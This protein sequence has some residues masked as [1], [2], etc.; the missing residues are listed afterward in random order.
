MSKKTKSS[1]K[2]KYVTVHN[3][4]KHVPVLL[5]EVLQYL[6]PQKGDTYLDVTAGYGGHAEAVLE[7]SQ[8]GATLIDRDGEAVKELQASFKAPDIEIVHSDFLSASKQL[9][10]D[11]RR[12]DM[13]VA[14][15][16]VSSPHLNISSRGFSFHGNAPL[17]MRMD[18]N[19]DLSAAEVVNSYPQERLM[20]I[21][22]NLGEEPKA[23]SIARAIVEQRPITDTSQLAAIATK[24]W[25][26]YSR[27]HPATR[28]F[29]AIRI[30][31]ND[32]LGQ[33]EAALPVWTELLEPDGRLV[34]ISFHSI[35]DRI[36]KQF[37]A[38]ESQGGYD[39]RL[40][41]LTKKPVTA[42]SA[43]LV[44]NPRA[45]SARLRA[46]VKIKIREGK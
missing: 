19:Q 16:G 23:A 27:T 39:S 36:V 35:E 42:T 30:A 29:Q 32:E 26:G 40:K 10:A 2:Q 43:E 4:N 11:G 45:R 25:P 34:V 24:A 3:Q 5:S 20:E 38:N 7:A 22:R 13:I 18:Q 41:L 21:F 31:V 28:L 37:L 33:L 6:A 46:A 12:Y 17:D 14:D 15:L 1:P 8:N 44:S 9:L